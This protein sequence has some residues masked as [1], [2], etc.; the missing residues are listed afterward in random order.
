MDPRD[1]KYTD[2][3]LWIVVN[4]SQ[5]TVGIAAHAAKHICPVVSVQLPEVGRSFARRKA[6]GTL[7]S[8]KAVTEMA[9]PLSGKVVAVNTGLR[10]HPQR[11]CE[12]PYDSWLVKVEITKPEE[13]A[14]LLSPEQ[15]AKTVASPAKPKPP[16]KTPPPKVRSHS[17]PEPKPQSGAVKPPDAPDRGKLIAL[18]WSMRLRDTRLRGGDDVFGDRDYSGGS[19]FGWR[20]RDIV[21][22]ADHRFVW[23]DTSFSRVST[24]GLSST[25]K[26]P[27]KYEGEWEIQV[28]AERPR[29]VLR[30]TERGVI[31]FSLEESGRNGSLLLDAKA[32]S[33]SRL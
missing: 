26:R 1:R 32:Y 21:L 24:A 2:D 23:Q 19:Y 17:A 8:A 13:I 7:E 27:T 16:P 31:T 5:A 4:G 20:E 29:L 14:K 6:F 10:A 25:L 22:S 33:W 28:V 18:S 12:D 15:Y 3:H 30:D 9:A 11:L